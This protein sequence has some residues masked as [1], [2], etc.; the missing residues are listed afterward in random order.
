MPT[1]AEWHIYVG[2]LTIISSDDGLDPGGRQVI[3]YT[4]AG[5]C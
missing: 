4:N 2:N 1:E 3:I 5:I